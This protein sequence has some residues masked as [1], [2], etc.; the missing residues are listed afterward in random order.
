MPLEIPGSFRFDGSSVKFI[1]RDDGTS[2]DFTALESKEHL[3]LAL[4]TMRKMAI[5]LESKAVGQPPEPASAA[6]PGVAG[7]DQLMQD[8]ERRHA[9]IVRESELRIAEHL[10]RAEALA[11]GG[12]KPADASR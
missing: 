2:V 11:G 8:S 4:T 7:V 9:E 12:Q 1:F 10:K 3:E 6:S 5:A